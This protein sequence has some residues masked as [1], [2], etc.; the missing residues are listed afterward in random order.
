MGDRSA[1]DEDPTA[2]EKAFL[3]DARGVVMRSKRLLPEYLHLPM[4]SGVAVENLAPGQ[5]VRSFEMQA[6]LELIRLTADNTRFQA[7]NIDIAKGYCLVVTDQNRREDHL[8]LDGNRRTARAA[9]ALPR[10][11]RAD[12]TG[13]PDGQSARRTQHAGHL[14]RTAAREPEDEPA[15]ATP[16]PPDEF[17]EGQ[18][19]RERS[20]D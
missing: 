7:R 18:V 15:P 14:C 9:D 20:K 3:I 17:G 13:N 1:A 19:R 4:I 16:P 11:H 10:F 12:G 2:S 6:A 5:R 8:R